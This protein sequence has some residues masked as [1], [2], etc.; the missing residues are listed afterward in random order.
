MFKVL[1]ISWNVVNRFTDMAVQ[2]TLKIIESR[3]S[4]YNN[5]KEKTALP[6]KVIADLL[7]LCT[8]RN[9][10][11][12]NNKIYQQENGMQLVSSL[13]PFFANIFA[14]EIEIKVVDFSEFKSK[15]QL[16]YVLRRFC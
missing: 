7:K 11:H 14:K 4:V 3:L 10:L 2:E 8:E 16:I 15:V 13:S 9:C 1:N 6:I 5:L 12:L